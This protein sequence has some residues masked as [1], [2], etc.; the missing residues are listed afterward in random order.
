MTLEIIVFASLA[1]KI[2]WGGVYSS[3]L[4]P[5]NPLFTRLNIHFPARLVLIMKNI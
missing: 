2:S 1:E 5:A 4:N 3:N